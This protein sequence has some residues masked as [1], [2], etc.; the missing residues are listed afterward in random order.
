MERAARRRDT[1]GQHQAPGGLPVRS[2]AGA[3]QARAH[4][5]YQ[6]SHRTTQAPGSG[7]VNDLAT[8]RRVRDALVPGGDSQ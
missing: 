7:R 5:E 6:G 4:L 8:L 1:G 2:S 3:A